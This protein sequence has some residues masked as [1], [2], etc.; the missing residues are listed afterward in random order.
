[1]DEVNTKL[2]YSIPEAA[3]ATSLSKSYL[4]QLVHQGKL[5]SRKVGG[6]RLILAE[7]L[8]KYLR[9]EVS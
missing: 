1:M 8:R 5:P 6:R 2:A 7:D 4:W 9:G 3:E